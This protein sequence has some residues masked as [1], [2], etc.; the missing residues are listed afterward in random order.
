[1]AFP[2]NQFFREES[3]TEEQIKRFVGERFGV[4]F[5]M[6]KKVEVN[7]VNASPLYRYLRF[8]SELFDRE[9]GLTRVVPWNFAKFVVDRNGKVIKFA[10]PRVKPKE[11]EHIIEKELIY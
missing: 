6:F 5:W 1:M 3:G 4:G 10:S 9:T 2:C 7:G 11:L 8:N